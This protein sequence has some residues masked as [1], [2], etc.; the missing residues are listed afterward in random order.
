VNSR[1]LLAVA[2][3]AIAVAILAARPR[4][5]PGP[6]LRDFEAYWAAG[7][8]WNAHADPYGRAI[9]NAERTV[10][11]VEPKRDEVLPFVGP[12]ATLPAWRLAARLPYAAAASLWAALLGASLL[13]LAAAVILGSRRT[14]AP[15]SFLAALA[16]AIGFGPVT[17]DLALGQL[18]LPAVLG[19]ALAVLVASRSLAGATAAACLAFAQPNASLGLLS[20]LGR[21]RATVAIVAGAAASYA[22]GALAAGWRWPAAYARLIAAHGAAERF[23]AIQL[24]PASIAYGFGAT[25][26]AAQV[27]GVVLVALAIAAAIVLAVTIRDGFARFAAFSAIAP[28]AA[29]FFHEHDLVVA[30][31]PAV[32]CAV[33]TS[34]SARV[35]ALAG[36]LLVAVDWL[37]LAQRP[38]GIAQSALLAI[39][40]LAAFAALGDA[41]ELRGTALVALAFVPCFL[42]AAW[43]AAHWPAPVWPDALHAFRA[44]SGVSIAAVWEHEQHASGLLAAV[45]AWA[46]LRSLSLAGCALLAYAIYRHS[47]CCRTA[48]PN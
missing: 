14:L 24:S 25:P 15:F 36:T 46:A 32:W 11:G 4:A 37:G 34:A 8:S 19:A 18:A 1:S 20:Q 42:A 27:V 41:A 48:S 28:F 23:A 13:A 29:G 22:L 2:C 30:Y 7:A 9:W 17:S 39:A 43:L 3:V 38:T 5:T 47:S 31:V 33:R 12:P 35:F 26:L 40:A 16:L 45:P 10:S 44:P 21:N 6:F